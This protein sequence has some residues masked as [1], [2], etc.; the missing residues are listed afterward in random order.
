MLASYE[1]LMFFFYCFVTI[2]GKGTSYS[3]LNLLA[4]VTDTFAAGYETTSTTLKWCI[5][6]MM[7]YPKVQSRV[8]EELDHVVGRDRLPTLDD[9][10][11]LP[12]TSAV[13]M[14]VSLM[15]LISISDIMA[16]LLIES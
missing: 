15:F 14:E 12:Y 11:D 2:Q 1:S 8:Q 13:L 16:P 4:S 9:R 5:L 3:K 7:A 6:Y 10:T